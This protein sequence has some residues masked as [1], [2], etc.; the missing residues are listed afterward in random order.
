MK[1]NNIDQ[2]LIEWLRISF[3]PFARFAIFVI[4]FWFGF[5]KIIGESP[6]SPLAFEL[7]RKT[8]GA[9][10]FHTLFI[11]VGIYEC[12]VGILFLLPKATRVV[13]PLL[14]GHMLIVCSPLLLVPSMAWTKPLVPTLEGQY[15]LKNLA[16]IALAI[17]I[18]AQTRPLARKSR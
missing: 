5:L 18:A 12:L 3:M 14:F 7:V 10:H 4:F 9:E 15:I 8:V 11:I 17:G 16:V 2:K 13:I 1:I 6:A